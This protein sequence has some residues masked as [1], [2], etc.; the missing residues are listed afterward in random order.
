M[1]KKAKDANLEQIGI[2]LKDMRIKKGYKSYVAFAIDNDLD[3][4]YYFGIEKGHRNFSIRYFFKLLEIH[5]ISQTEFM[6]I[7]K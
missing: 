1:S 7:L 6:K 4:K 5:E 2:L 3:P